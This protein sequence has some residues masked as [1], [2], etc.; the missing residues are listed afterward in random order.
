MS[1][2]RADT[3]T[4]SNGTSPVTLTKQSAAKAWVSFNA[5]PS[6]GD[7]LNITSLT[8]SASGRPAA[9]YIS[10][11][12]NDDYASAGMCGQG[13]TTNPSAVNFDASYGM[14]STAS[15]AVVTSEGS[16]SKRDY[17]LTTILV[18]GDLA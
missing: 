15:I 10:A 5:T 16:D 17:A 13:Q 2:L 14:Q 12:A 4:A 3:I 8:D 11:M 7:S 6:V 18:H 1:E 9:N